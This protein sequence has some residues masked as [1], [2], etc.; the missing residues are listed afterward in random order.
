VGWF[1]WI[2]CS[3]R[4]LLPQNSEAKAVKLFRQADLDG[5]GGIDLDEFK[6]GVELH[7]GLSRGCVP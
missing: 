2:G 1:R 6:V 7:L 4:P 3:L 5:S